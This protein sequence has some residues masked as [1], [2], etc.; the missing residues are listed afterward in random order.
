MAT[1]LNSKGSQVIPSAEELIER[2]RA[3]VPALKARAAQA[4]AEC[5]VPD[6]TIAEMQAAGFFR[7][8]QPKRW[9]GY[10]MHPNVFF[11]VQKLL[12]QGCMSTGWVY[13]VVGGHPYELA[14]FH[15]QAQV[16]VWGEDDSILVSSSYQPVGKVE[17]AEG[18]FYLSGRWGFSS[19]SE[20]CQW[21]LLGAMIPPLNAGDP[22][23]M[24][25]FL[26]PRSDYAIDRT[27]DVFGLQG[28]GSHDIIVERA[29]V[30]DYR[31][32]KS[33]DGFLCT[34]PGQKENDAPLFRLPWAQVFLR[35]VSSSALGGTRAAIDAALQITKDR[36][37][38]N[39][40]KAS[41]SD[42]VL[43]NAIAKA[44]AQ[45]DEMELT[46]R[47][48]FDDLI[49]IAET[50]EPIPMDKRTLYR[51]QSASVVRR[52]ADL[53]DDLM[54]L[55]GGRAIYN[56]SP[57]VQPWLDLNAARA[58]VANDPN[59]MGPDLTNGLMGEGPSFF[60]L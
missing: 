2:A 59:N 1:A 7:I 43:L 46:L 4:T 48:N 23:D 31:T 45:L 49:A 41:K 25:T 12:A 60:F 42:P 35:L 32:H 52:C 51:F 15:N 5:K 11:E 39:T 6:E 19:G 24:R 8:L 3:M 33:S 29:F 21:V 44:Y 27:W 47:R 30:P 37:S 20:H 53:V 18:G 10:E 13:G 28:T 40:G 26:V 58:H 34:N 9:G 14:L 55:L 50:G 36:V 56:S 38:T 22:P 57:I 16:D 54:P 17:R